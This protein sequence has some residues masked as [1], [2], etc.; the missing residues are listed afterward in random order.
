M[1]SKG[2][3]DKVRLMLKR[4]ILFSAVALP[5]FLGLV[6][7]T[8]SV[9]AAQE[10]GSVGITGTI[11]SPPPTTGATI[12][13]P[14]NG[15]TITSIPV[16][17]SGICPN[18]LL[19][20]LFKN[21]VFAG[22]VQCDN[23]SFS[24]LADLFPGANELIARVYDELDQAGPD[25]NTVNVTFI[26]NS[27]NATMANRPSL[28][29]NFAKRGANPGQKLTWPILLTGGV[30][31]YAVSI[32]W[33]DGKTDLLS[34]QNPQEFII[35]HTYDT[36]GVYRIVIKVADARDALAFLQLTAVANGPLSQ[37]NDQSTENSASTVKTKTIWW[38]AALL[39]PFIL[40][41]F[42]LGK[43]Y[44]KRRIRRRIE[45]GQHPF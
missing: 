35:D 6:F 42:W 17:V 10:Q 36:A 24:I 3:K 14:I 32:E 38:P 34:L 18:G 27:A 30:G 26:D 33:G 22:S 25:S 23:G 40:S 2:E 31:P 19:V 43:K 45:D 15:T 7:V 21:G 12:S 9:Y 11:P 44:E 28:T 5:F 20:K 29:S 41:T 37:T 13:L 16:T 1:R 4:I 39:I 8:H